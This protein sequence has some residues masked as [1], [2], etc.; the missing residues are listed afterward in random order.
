MIYRQRD[1]IS[2]ALPE[3]VYNYGRD[4]T[5][6]HERGVTEWTEFAE[7]SQEAVGRNIRTYRQLRDLDQD[8]L[9]RRLKRLAIPWRRVTVSEVERGERHVTVPELVGLALAL[10]H[11]SC[12]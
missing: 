4:D 9:A 5:G 1:A 2:C 3:R 11:A 7:D 12:S 10:G 8:A 6:Q